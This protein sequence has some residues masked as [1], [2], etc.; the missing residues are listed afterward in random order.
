MDILSQ[1]FTFYTNMIQKKGNLE[2]AEGG[3]W[4]QGTEENGY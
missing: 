2:K 3:L 4:V 1:N